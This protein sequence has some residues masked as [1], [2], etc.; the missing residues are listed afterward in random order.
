MSRFLYFHTPSG[1]SWEVSDPVQWCIDNAH[2]PLLKRA[3]DRLLTLTA[4]DRERVIRLVTRRCRLTLIE[5]QP[6]RV[7][8][9]HWGED[10]Q[11][12]L[13]SFL[14]KESLAKQGVEVFLIDRKREV[15]TASPGDNFL[16]GERLPQDF[17]LGLYRQKWRCRGQVEPDDRTAAPAS[18][19]SFVWEG[20]EPGQMSWAVL[21][22]VWRK[23]NSPLC[24]N[25]EGSTILT[26]CGRVQCGMFNWRYVLRHACLACGRQFE[27]NLTADLG[28]WLVAHLDWPLL[29]GFQMIWGK[30]NKW[31]PP[32]G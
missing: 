12:D 28:K 5:I 7:V 11:G 17:P 8:I 2:G 16:Y 24:P 32:V 22:S 10:G 27:E 13:R 3:R 30:P 18:W 29:P 21:K 31:Q 14:N 26:G 19:S 4:D 1:K 23:E 20:I 6:A 9:H 25:C 15:I